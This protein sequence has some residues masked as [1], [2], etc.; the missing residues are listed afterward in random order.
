MK[1]ERSWIA[2]WAVA[3]LSA[4]GGGGDFAPATG[5]ANTHGARALASQES[6]GAN[7]ATGGA[8]IDTG[9]DS[10]GNG[11]LDASEI[12]ST[13]YVCNGTTGAAGAIGATGLTGLTGATGVAGAT[14]LAALVQMSAE[15]AGSHCANGGTK[16]DAGADS[17]ANG[18]LD[19]AEIS[20]IAYVC[21]GATGTSGAA[22]AIGAAGSNGADG[23]NGTNGAN[24]VD[25]LMSIVPEAPG[26]NCASGGARVRSGL[27]SNRNGSLEPGEITTTGFVC[28]GSNGAVGSN[29]SNSL[30]AIVAEASGSNCAS[31]GRKITSG[32]DGNGNGTLE[33]GEV[34]STAY[35]CNG[36]TGA[37]GTNGT[38]GAAGTNGT[39][40][41]AGTNGTNGAAGSNGNNGADGF[42]TLT[43]SVA[44]SA[45]IHCAAGGMKITSG[46]DTSRDGVLDAGEVTATSYVCNGQSA[47]GWIDVV[48]PTM[49]A[50]SNTGYVADNAAQVTVT[51]PASPN[52]GDVVRVSGAGAGGWAIA[53]NAGQAIATA[54]LDVATIAKT[55][56]IAPTPVQD[57]RAV[58]SSADGNRLVAAPSQGTLMASADAGQTWA[59]IGAS[60]H[61]TTVASSADGRRLVAAGF[62]ESVYVSGDY[63]ATWTPTLGPTGWVSVASSSDGRVLAAVAS[64]I[65]LSMSYDYGASW[66]IVLGISGNWSSV[67]V[68]GDG[69]HAIAAENT[70]LVW[71]SND[72]GTNWYSPGAL[73][74]TSWT[75]VA[76]S[77]DGSRLVAMA[78]G[79]FI[80]TSD[81]YGNS[82]VQR[83]NARSWNSVTSSADGTRLVAVTRDDGFGDLNGSSGAVYTSSDQGASWTQIGPNDAWIS[84]AS[85]ADGNRWVAASFTYA[86]NG[87]LTTSAP[88]RASATTPGITGTLTGRQYQ[89]IELQYIG[90]GVFVVLDSIGTG[91]GV[92]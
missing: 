61:W 84:V 81:D 1:L 62:G 31:G 85:S 66:S 57:W 55:W 54:N 78:Y 20:S 83:D 46:V 12:V 16:V 42:T 92:F 34:T 77:S 79:G 52:V 73:P 19:L 18:M 2:A 53:Q 24:G 72:G 67:A 36:A 45:G 9:I 32:V 4:C 21:A 7:C 13:Q 87:T 3:A 60:R 50:V 37:A 30:I 91:F 48:T 43:L 28:N 82:W 14:G 10:N 63:G 65:M 76:S 23:T 17:N 15:P 68:S 89:A 44:E 40:G 11:V 6:P 8:R 74:S 47:L 33:P 58:A 22:G 49:Q 5:A 75:A 26:T 29:G 80:Y 69:R 51:L 88:T 86:G 64:G 39:N 70:G 90:G 71:V 35:V 38:N 27:D 59:G 56:T 41:A 25:T